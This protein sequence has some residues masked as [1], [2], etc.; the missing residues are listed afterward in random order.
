MGCPRRS[1]AHLTL[2]M[3]RMLSS[4]AKHTYNSAGRFSATGEPP[5]PQLCRG[6]DDEMRSSFVGPMP[7]KRFF[8]TFLPTPLKFSKSERDGLVGFE[9]MSATGS[10]NQMYDGFVRSC[11]IVPLPLRL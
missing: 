2:I 9:S 3:S 10:E 8:Q 5:A 11:L 4:P 6:M 1:A 7:V